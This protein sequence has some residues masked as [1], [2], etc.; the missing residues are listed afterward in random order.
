MI[1]ISA[2]SISSSVPVRPKVLM[3][4]SAI[5]RWMAYV[6]AERIRSAVIGTSLGHAID[7]AQWARR[8]RGGE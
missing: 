2:W 7:G 5:P 4:A 8:F 1:V 6:M 3:M